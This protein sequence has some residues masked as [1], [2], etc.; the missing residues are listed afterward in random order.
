[1]TNAL[2]AVYST[3]T[4][5]SSCIQFNQIQSNDQQS[6]CQPPCRSCPLEQIMTNKTTAV[7]L[8]LVFVMIANCWWL[9]Q[10]WQ[11]CQK[12]Y[13]NSLAQAICLSSK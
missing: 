1:V 5:R 3:G 7:I 12:L 6:F 10:K 11:A 4:G 13:S 9:P 8:F 2:P